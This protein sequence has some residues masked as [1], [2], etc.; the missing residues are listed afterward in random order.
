MSERERIDALIERALDDLEESEIEAIRAELGEEPEALEQFNDLL[1]MK[2]LVPEPL[3]PPTSMDARILEAARS[4]AASARGDA[5]ALAHRGSGALG[6]LSRWLSR[7]VRGPQ[8]AMATV[9]LLVVALSLFFVP[10]RERETRDDADSALTQATRELPRS[11]SGTELPE[12][13]PFMKVAGEGAEEPSASATASSAGLSRQRKSAAPG[14]SPK[15]QERASAPPR[16][17]AKESPPAQ[18]AE[19]RWPSG[20]AMAGDAALSRAPRSA[21]SGAPSMATRPAQG[22]SNAS[23]QTAMRAAGESV[24]FSTSSAPSG[25]DARRAEST[26]TKR[27]E[28][29]SAREAHV[30]SLRRLVERRAYGEAIRVGRALLG[31]RSGRSDEIAEI[32]LLL[33]RAEKGAGRCDRSMPLYERLVREYPEKAGAEG[34]VAEMEACAESAR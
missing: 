22:E 2:A 30:D 26:P 10:L 3:A 20:D 21:S 24:S 19:Q 9:S 15:A 1:A 12:G 31:T 25:S 8:V 4:A 7:V 5:D 29:A 18:D 17:A 14:G 27:D 11:P 23:A 33:A 28:A 34:I 6:N 16:L 13:E 32:L